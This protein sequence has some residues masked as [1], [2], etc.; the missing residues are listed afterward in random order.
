MTGFD[1][2]HVPAW[3]ASVWVQASPSSHGVPSGFVGF[4][5]RPVAGLQ[6][7]ASWH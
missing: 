7:P 2:V 4:E 5:Q 1:P 3:Q 6:A